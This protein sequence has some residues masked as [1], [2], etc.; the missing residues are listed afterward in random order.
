MSKSYSA[1]EKRIAK[2]LSY[3]PGLKYWIKWLYQMLNYLRYKKDYAF[4]SKLELMNICRF[5]GES[6]FGYYDKSPEN[7][8]GRFIILQKSLT[9]TSKK[10]ECKRG[11]S[12]ILEDRIEDKQ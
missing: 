8:T 9:E 6:F 10:P 2:F 4:N 11:V 1:K 5:S 3:L 12:V 7:S